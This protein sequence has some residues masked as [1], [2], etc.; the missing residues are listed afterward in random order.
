MRLVL[1]ALASV[2]DR[3][4]DFILLVK[5]QFEV[6]RAD[7]GKGGVVRDPQLWRS[8]VEGVIE[9]GVSLGLGPRGAVASS[10]PGPAGNREFFVHLSGSGSEI[11]AGD[12]V[13]R[14][15]A[16]AAGAEAEG[17]A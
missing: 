10:P 12:A 14:A 15:V 16:T 4:A 1:P 5:P 8:A 2:A 17:P 6:G 13:E 7:V 11:E 9:V 3:G